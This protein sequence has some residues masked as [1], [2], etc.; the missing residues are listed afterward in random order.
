MNVLPFYWRN[1]ALFVLD[2]RLLPSTLRYT[3][4]STPEA[5]AETI[6]NM[7]VRGAPAIGCCAAYGMALAGLKIQS[8]AAN[9]PPLKKTAAMLKLARP[10][11]VNL[12]WAVDRML[13]NNGA[14]SEAQRIEQEDIAINTAIARHGATLL[15]KNSTV[16]THCNTGALA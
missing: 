2:Q 3:K 7:S 15:K 11:A 1:K 13:A 14:L 8:K 5:V 16:I 6:R 9:I 10:T 4:C 12:A